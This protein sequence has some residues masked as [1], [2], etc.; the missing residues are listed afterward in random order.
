[1]DVTVITAMYGGYDSLSPLP[2]GHG[3]AEAICVT[4]D[5]NLSV[6]GWTTV[7]VPSE[8]GFR[9]GAKAPKLTPFR[10]ASHNLAVWVDGSVTIVDTTFRQFCLDALADADL[11]AW[12]HPENRDCLF[13]EAAYCQ[14]WPQN[15]KM[16]LREQ[17]ANYRAEGMPEHYG[18]WASGILGWRKTE[19]TVAFGEAWFEENRRWS[20]RDQVSFPYM[21]WKMRPRFGVFPAHQFN[22]AYVRYKN[23][24]VRR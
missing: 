17:T 9:L 6:E 23:H 24:L 18:L 7:H 4:D 2:D 1:M 10:W 12:N 22:N 20:T 21:V 3:F 19:E 11:V 8:H 14:D 5:P 16:P 13:Q 15:R